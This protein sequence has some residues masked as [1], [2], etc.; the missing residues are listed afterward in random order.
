MVRELDRAWVCR[1]ELL[2]T[3][4]ATERIREEGSVKRRYEVEISLQRV[5]RLDA[6]PEET[7]AALVSLNRKLTL[8]S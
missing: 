7:K 6:V 8:L 4:M 3:L 1:E 2:Y 5:L